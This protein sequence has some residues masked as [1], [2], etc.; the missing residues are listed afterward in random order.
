MCEQHT[1][2]CTSHVWALT[3]AAFSPC[4][5]AAAISFEVTTAGL[6]DLSLVFSVTRLWNAFNVPLS[7]PE[8]SSCSSQDDGGMADGGNAAALLPASK[9]CRPGDMFKKLTSDAM[10]A[11]TWAQ[12][13][14][15]MVTGTATTVAS[16]RRA[17]AGSRDN[18]TSS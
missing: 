5:C 18:R 1:G 14:M 15:G 12:M 6:S 10:T 16:A 9:Q 3:I 2:L 8:H 17:N 13:W 11:R 7:L 4:F